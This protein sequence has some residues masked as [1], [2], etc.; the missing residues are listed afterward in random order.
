MSRKDAPRWVSVYTRLRR[1]VIDFRISREG[2]AGFSPEAAY[3]AR[4]ALTMGKSDIRNNRLGALWQPTVADKIRGIWRTG[5]RDEE[6]G[7]YAITLSFP[8]ALHDRDA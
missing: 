1:A 2:I 3:P 8:T 5:E 4:P 7:A 6:N